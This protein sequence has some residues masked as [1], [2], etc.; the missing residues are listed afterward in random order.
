MPKPRGE[1]SDAFVI[2][3]VPRRKGVLVVLDKKTRKWMLP[4]G[5][6]DWDPVK[7]KKDPS[8]R[9]G[10]AR[11]L[12]EEGGYTID[13]AK[14]RRSKEDPHIFY[15]EAH[16]VNWDEVF[17]QRKWGE[18]S[19]YGFA[20]CDAVSWST[21][22]KSADMIFEFTVFGHDGKIKSPIQK[23]RG[24]GERKQL[25]TALVFENGF[26]SQNMDAWK[27]EIDE[28]RE[29]AKKK[30]EAKLQLQLQPAACRAPTP[31]TVTDYA[32]AKFMKSF[33]L[34]ALSGFVMGS[35][36]MMGAQYYG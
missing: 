23:W 29:R 30:A 7:G 19:D 5:G 36:A 14:L 1:V 12:Q 32:N 33:A 4:G 3:R 13:P 24:R 21:R 35:A 26:P 25:Y 6:V 9:H 22:E 17:S 28:A 27:Q 31:R 2:L 11:E 15:G 34:G 16:R 8:A 20:R 18:T 10:A